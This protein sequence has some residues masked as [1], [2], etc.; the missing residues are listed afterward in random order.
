MRAAGLLVIFGG[1]AL[2]AVGVQPYTGA[3]DRFGRLPG[4]INAGGG[5][6]RIFAPITS[7]PLVSLLLSLLLYLLRR[8]F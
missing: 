3:L 5:R 7:L 4:D 1:L 6:G 2:V 8:F